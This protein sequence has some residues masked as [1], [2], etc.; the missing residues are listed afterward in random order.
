MVKDADHVVVLDVGRVV[1][2][3]TRY[4]LIARGGRFA[5][6]ARGDTGT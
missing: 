2:T 4:E 3:G 6:F 1:D 5:H